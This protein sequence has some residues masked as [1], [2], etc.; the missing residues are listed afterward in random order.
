MATVDKHISS[1]QQ[2]MMGKSV[3]SLD[4]L[5]S[6]F[7]DQLRCGLD[8]PKP[9]MPIFLRFPFVALVCLRLAIE[10]ALAQQSQAQ[11]NASM[12][13]ALGR[14]QLVNCIGTN[15]CFVLSSWCLL[16]LKHMQLAI[17]LWSKWSVKVCQCQSPHN[18]LLHALFPL[19]STTSEAVA[20]VFLV[21]TMSTLLSSHII[22]VTRCGGGVSTCSG[23]WKVMA[24][25][26]PRNLEALDWAIPI[27][28]RSI[29]GSLWL[30]TRSHQAVL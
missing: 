15:R 1:S 20:F 18:C 21:G 25:R 22:A 4:D 2:D 8:L 23:T 14:R 6:R 11:T 16:G 3:A 12:T 28:S 9:T 30:T 27:L 7:R 24:L 19:T 10:K 29:I 26:L 17:V 13:T 5:K